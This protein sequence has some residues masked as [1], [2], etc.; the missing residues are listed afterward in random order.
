MRDLSLLL[1]RLTVGGLLAGHGAQKLFG[2]FDGPGLKGAAGMMHS[3]GIRPGDR[4]AF[5]AG[6]SEFGGGSLTAAGLLGPLGPI[7][8]MGSM[9]MA[10]TTVHWGKPIW[11]TSGGAELPVT[12]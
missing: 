12:Y 3:I 10:A 9:V 8:A 2:A 1:V 7:A 11:V 5:M 6:L 4:W